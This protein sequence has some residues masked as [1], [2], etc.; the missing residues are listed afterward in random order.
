M[1]ILKIDDFAFSLLSEDVRA[2]FSILTVEPDD[3]ELFEGDLE[4]SNLLSIKKKASKKLLDY[5]YKKR[6]NVRD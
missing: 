1:I 4:F 5:K 3:K 2:E 6:H